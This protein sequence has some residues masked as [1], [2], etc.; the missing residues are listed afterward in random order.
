[1]AHELVFLHRQPDSEHINY[2]ACFFRCLDFGSGSA[3]AVLTVEV[4]IQSPP[5]EGL[6]FFLFTWVATVAGTS[7]EQ[8]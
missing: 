5:K 2:H 1:M 7:W 6:W 8:T 4:P 3:L